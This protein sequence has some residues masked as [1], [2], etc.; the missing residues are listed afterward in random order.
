MNRQLPSEPDDPSE[1]SEVGLPDDPPAVHRPPKISTPKPAHG[2][3]GVVAVILREERFLVIRRSQEVT[4]P[5]KLCFPGGGIEPGESEEQTL[6][7]EMLE[8]LALEVSPVRLLWRSRT[9]WGTKLAWWLADTPEDPQL[10]PDPSEVEEVFWMSR[11]ELLE[12]EDLLPSVPQFMR[13][14][15]TGKLSLPID[16]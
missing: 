7:R 6:Q 12:A 8:E 1:T 2:R 14:W 5:G 16:W 10:H 15:R 4:A 11:L 9:P 13:A 3:R